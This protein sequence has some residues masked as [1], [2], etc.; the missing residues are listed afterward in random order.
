MNKTTRKKVTKAINEGLEN[1]EGMIKISDRIGKVYNEF[2]TWRSDLIARTESTAGNNE[3]FISAYKQSGVA[4]HKE[5]IATMDDRTREEHADMNGEIVKLNESFSN[6]SQYPDEP[7]C[8]CVI[9][10]AFES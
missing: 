9:G 5:W 3:G 1:G 6:G 7:N 10:P 4:T 2:P 8:R